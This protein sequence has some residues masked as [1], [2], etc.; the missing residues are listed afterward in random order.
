MRGSDIVRNRFLTLSL[1]SATVALTIQPG[2]AGGGSR[3]RGG[4]ARFLRSATGVAH[5]PGVVIIDHGATVSWYAPQMRSSSLLT[6]LFVLASCSGEPPSV[7]LVSAE[8]VGTVG[9][10]S[11]LRG[12]DGGY[13]IDAFGRSIWFFGDTTLDM[14]DERGE[15]WL[16]NSW[17]WS[18]SFD[19]ND[20]IQLQDFPDSVGAPTEPFPLTPEEDEFNRVHAGDPCQ[21]EPCGARW[22][23]WPG[24]SVYDEPRDRVVTFYGK[25]SAVPG[26][27]N[28]HSVGQGVAT[29]TG[30]GAPVERPIVRPA[31]DEPTLLFDSS[32]PPY[33]GAAWL[34]GATL[35]AWGCL[36]DGTKKPCRVARVDIAEVLDPAAWRFWSGDEW[37]ADAAAA[38]PV[39][40]GNDI[41]TVQRIDALDALV[42]V[43][44]KPLG[45]DVMYRT[46]PRP[47]G[48]WSDARRAF[49][50]EEPDSDSGWIYDAI[51]HPEFAEDGGRTQYLTYSRTTGFFESELKLM[52]LSFAE[53]MP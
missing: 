15:Q 11:F 23:M 35:Y 39:F 25:I 9:E 34:D 28:F 22:A 20:G 27:F 31:A 47:E 45:R 4:R 12:R 41:L 2:C 43:Y 6:V 8:D 46:A 44:S 24:A 5:E 40:D 30:I 21:V 18:E 53:Q 51:V 32:L 49:V 1:D 14:P 33:G 48:P 7:I 3:Q 52:R 38:A 29:W 26:N 10:S 17:S 36:L 16:H 13:S 42:A 19:A 50:A 37:T